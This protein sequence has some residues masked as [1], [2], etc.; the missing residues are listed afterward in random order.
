MLLAMLLHI[1]SEDPLFLVG[2]RI[3]SLLFYDQKIN[4]QVSFSNR[5]WMKSQQNM[6]VSWLQKLGWNPPEHEQTI[7]AVRDSALQQLLTSKIN[8]LKHEMIQGKIV[9]VE[10]SK[11]GSIITLEDGTQ[12]KPKVIVSTRPDP[13]LSSYAQIDTKSIFYQQRMCSSFCTLSDDLNDVYIRSY[14]NGFISL[15]PLDN[16][17][18]ILKYCYGEKN[19]V[20]RK[21]DKSAYLDKV[22]TQLQQISDKD[23]Q[24][25]FKTPLSYPPL[26][27]DE[28][29][30][31][32]EKLLAW[33]Q[34]TRFYNKNVIVLGDAAH[35]FYPFLLHDSN[36]GFN[37]VAV[38]AN[39][40]AA[41]EAKKK[42]VGEGYNRQT[43][44]VANTYG[45]LQHYLKQIT[46]S[47]GFSMKCIQAFGAGLLNWFPLAAYLLNEVAYGAVTP[48]FSLDFM[49]KPGST[50]NV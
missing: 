40:V 23:T 4:A 47:E 22:N 16:K 41:A 44:A 30:S 11:E 49:G 28:T 12:I 38:L 33:S 8:E 32:T 13:V 9:S 48:P 36:I 1:Q 27:I 24:G 43:T 39:N 7:L 10:G 5:L 29:E 6:F 34:S 14:P 15:I 18:A 21:L 35:E 17:Q 50:T 31:R 25:W 20:T 19:E 45:N 3:D 26:I 42:G 46:Q 37:E 2:H